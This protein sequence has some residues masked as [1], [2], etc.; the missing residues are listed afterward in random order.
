M[1]DQENYYSTLSD[2][3]DSVARVEELER[4]KTKLDICDKD[5]RWSKDP[6]MDRLRRDAKNAIE[7]LCDALKAHNKEE[8]A[9]LYG[10]LYDSDSDRTVNKLFARMGRL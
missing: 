5:S 3:A 8:G 10:K 6:N 7:E 9:R 1:F 2:Y 4:L